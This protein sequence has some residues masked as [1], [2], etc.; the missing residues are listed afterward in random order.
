M[1]SLNTSLCSGWAARWVQTS[2]P[3]SAENAFSPVTTLC[4]RWPH[5]AHTAGSWSV[6]ARGR[7]LAW[8]SERSPSPRDV[9]VNEPSPVRS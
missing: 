9:L 3:C 5:A 7:M 6:L 1:L 8:T 4:L 2:V